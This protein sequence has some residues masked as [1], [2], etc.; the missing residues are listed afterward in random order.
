MGKAA[1]EFV[2]AN[3]SL[4]RDSRRLEAVY[5]EALGEKSAGT[6]PLRAEPPG[7]RVP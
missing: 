6:V 1:R 5:E 4:E 2:T 3:F 7:A